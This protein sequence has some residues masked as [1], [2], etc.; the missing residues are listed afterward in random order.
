MDA[1][2]VLKSMVAISYTFLRILL[3]LNSDPPKR[4]EN[5]L[6]HRNIEIVTIA[7]SGFLSSRLRTSAP[8]IWI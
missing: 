6:Q 5:H 3:P 4:I 2:G 8:G 7:S 1:G